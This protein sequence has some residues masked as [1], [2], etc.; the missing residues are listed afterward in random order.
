MKTFLRLTIFIFLTMTG[1]TSFAGNA[2]DTALAAQP[3]DVKA[4]YSARHPA[5]T[6]KFFGLKPGMTVVEALPGGGWYS[7]IL[8]SLLGSEGKLIGA[9]YA[10]DLYPK[11]NF[12]DDTYLEAKKTWVDSWTSKAK[13]WNDGEGASIAAFHFGSM[14][15]NM[16]DTADAVLLIRALHNLARFENDGAYLSSALA[17]IKRVL[18]PGGIIGVVQHM[19]PDSNSDAWANGS[20]GYLKKAFV[21]KTITDAGFELVDE[22]DV[23]SNSADQPSEEDIVW[24]LPPSFATSG[25]NAE[26]KAKYAAIGESNR[27]TLLFRKAK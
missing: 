9:D 3:D 13:A 5:E 16:S 17:E 20:R 15:D 6:L 1:S 12:Y 19:A 24:R 11:F 7:K 4:R 10:I 18:K 2:L 23:N 26:M 27:M 8:K 21:I 25:D 14:P 22:S